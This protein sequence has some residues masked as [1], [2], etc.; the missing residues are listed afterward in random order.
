M[1]YFQ[2]YLA[3]IG[4]R[5]KR[6][7]IVGESHEFYNEKESELASKIIDRYSIVGIEDTLEEEKIP[8]YKRVSIFAQNK[9][10]YPAGN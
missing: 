8:W 2:E 7:G 3:R 10:I 6:L 9:L 4:D 5:Q 1:V